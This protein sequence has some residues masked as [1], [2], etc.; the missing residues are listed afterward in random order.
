MTKFIKAG[1]RLDKIH[2]RNLK[3][4][5]A[6]LSPT[7]RRLVKTMEVIVQCEK[8]MSRAE[9]GGDMSWRKE[10]WGMDLLERY[11]K[12]IQRRDRIREKHGIEHDQAN[13]LLASTRTVRFSGGSF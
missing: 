1:I 13:E 7:E 12:A 2:T 6:H 8:D 4:H 5:Y 9:L 10:Q 3:S 11:L